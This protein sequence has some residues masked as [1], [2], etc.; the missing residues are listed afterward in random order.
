LTSAGEGLVDTLAGRDF[1]KPVNLKPSRLW[2][3]A[4]AIETQKDYFFS[5]LP[6]L[7]C[8]SQAALTTAIAQGAV[9]AL[10]SNET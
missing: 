2:S 9:T 4:G 1:G 5:F 6:S 3:G 10:S 8:L 7:N